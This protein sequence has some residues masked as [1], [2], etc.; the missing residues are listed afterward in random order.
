MSCS[1]LL[2]TQSY[3]DGE[4]SGAAADA[5]ES[6]LQSCPQ[7]QAFAAQAADLSDAL[8]R[9]DRI[10][11]PAS[12][13]AAVQAQL[14]RETRRF[15]PRSFWI[16]AGSG[17]AGSALAA[18]IA[19][20]MLLPPSAASLS[21][22]VADA[23]ARALTSGKP[24]M[25][26][27]SNHH[28]VKPWLAAHAGLSPPVAD[29]AADGYKLTGGRVDR[30]AGRTSAVAVYSHG[31]HELDL[32]SW[33]D[34]GTGLP[35]ATMLRGFR[36]AFWKQGDMDFAAISDMDQAAFEKFVTLAKAQRE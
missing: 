4:L 8:R 10:H 17:L 23:H 36:M 18:G 25:V 31:N 7:C 20:L 29:F 6:H 22:S 26:A 33:Q 11:V 21:Q 3:L 12:L 16:G 24:I 19:L 1:E 32:F 27:S 15:S 30:I 34:R 2:Q 35:D 5:A 13:R 14:D 9:A 28:T